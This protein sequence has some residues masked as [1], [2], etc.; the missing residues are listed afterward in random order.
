LQIFSTV[1][2]SFNGCLPTL[3]YVLNLFDYTIELLFFTF[4]N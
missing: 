2:F 1:I 4:I 3:D